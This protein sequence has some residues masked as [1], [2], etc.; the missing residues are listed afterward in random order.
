[1]QKPYSIILIS[2]LVILN[3]LLLFSIKISQPENKSNQFN[4]S[5]MALEYLDYMSEQ[6]SKNP[7]YDIKERPMAV[8]VETELYNLCNLKLDA[9]A[10]KTYKS[11]VTE[12][13]R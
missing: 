2:F 5:K 7:T 4:C 8:D 10:L 9:Q 1:M 11:I 13:Y 12:K 3:F 6:Y